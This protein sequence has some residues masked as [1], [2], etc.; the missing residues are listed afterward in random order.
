MARENTDGAASR[1]GD[2]TRARILQAAMEAFARRGFDG[3]SVRSIAAR[4]GL[5]DAAVFYYFPTKRHLLDALW[6]EAPVGEFPAPVPG[7]PLGPDVIRELVIATMR[8]SARNFT[9]LRLVAR[10]VLRSDETA[11]ALRNASRARWRKAIRAHFEPAG[12]R[13]AAL[14]DLFVAA[15]TGY[16]LRIE[17]QQGDNYPAHVL[18]PEV[19]H[20]VVTAVLRLMPIDTGAAAA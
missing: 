11:I 2:R 19:Q 6:D 20:R 1:S 10:E 12:P 13:A 3:T 18:D 4:C 8:T 14:V 17:I 16:L 15:V 7:R 9:Y 5:T